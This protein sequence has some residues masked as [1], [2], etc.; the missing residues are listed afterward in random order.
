MKV[1]QRYSDAY[2]KQSI[3]IIERQHQT[4]KDTLLNLKETYKQKHMKKTPIKLAQHL[5]NNTI[6]K[7]TGF[8]QSSL[9]FGR[10]YNLFSID[11]FDYNK[12]NDTL[13]YYNLLNNIKN[14]LN[15][16]AKVKLDRYKRVLKKKIRKKHPTLYDFK[17][18]YV[19]WYEHE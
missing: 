5:Y 16:K 7:Y 9:I 13:S 11:E 3:G 8:K 15:Q 6:K 4:L 14:K 12:T 18:S 10:Y 2:N 1:S 19:V 17:Q